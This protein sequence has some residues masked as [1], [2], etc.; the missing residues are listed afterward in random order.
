M[1][2]SSCA[3]SPLAM[4]FVVSREKPLSMSVSRFVLSL[5]CASVS[6]FNWSR[7]L[8]EPS[9]L[10]GKSSS[11]VKGAGGDTQAADVSCSSLMALKYPG[12]GCSAASAT[13]QAQ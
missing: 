12:G 9:Y 4:Y 7:A 13:V 11:P 6:G 2:H 8:P 5:Y 10:L 1:A 3:G